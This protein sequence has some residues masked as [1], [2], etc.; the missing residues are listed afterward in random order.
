MMEKLKTCPFCGKDILYRSQ[1]QLPF[2]DFG[3]PMCLFKCLYC[4]ARVSFSVD[5]DN[6]AA[7]KWNRRA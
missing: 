7:T 1:K 5:N 2:A 3:D 6:E 4:G